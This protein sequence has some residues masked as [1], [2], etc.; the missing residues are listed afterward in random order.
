MNTEQI[1]LDLKR[2]RD[3]LTQ[4]INALEGR[5]ARSAA[6]GRRGRRHM[7]AATRANMSRAMKAR[8][9]SGKM[10]GNRK[11]TTA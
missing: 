5:S 6:N 4:A 9:A 3:R 1:L 7:S 10:K 11:K 2:Q 8:W